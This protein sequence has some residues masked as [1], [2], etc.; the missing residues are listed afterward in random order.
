MFNNKTKYIIGVL[1]VSSILL[2][3]C[4]KETTMA[5]AA[6]EAASPSMP[7]RPDWVYNEP[8]EEDG[9]LSFVGMSNVHAS[10]Q[11]AR[12]DARRDAINNV[13][14]YLGTMAKTKFEQVTQSYGL[15]SQIVDPTT[16]AQQFEKQMSANLA[17]EMK[18]K[19]WHPEREKKSGVWG[20]KYFVLAQIPKSSIDNSFRKSLDQNIKKQQEEA[21]KAATQKAKEQSENAIDMFRKMKKEGLME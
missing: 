9:T 20:Y 11:N 5:P 6:V 3:G 19:T 16:A 14:Q 15:S 8:S 17:R 7:E 12:K 13:V 2:V 1:G 18:T 21:E 10:E 4:A